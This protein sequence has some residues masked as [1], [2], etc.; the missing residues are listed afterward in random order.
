MNQKIFRLIVADV[1][2]S[3]KPWE[4]LRKWRRALGIRAK[5]VA[6]DIGVSPSVISDYESG[7]RKSP[8]AEMVR[9]IVFS[10]VK[11]S[12]LRDVGEAQI[13]EEH[14]NFEEYARKMNGTIVAHPEVKEAAGIIKV[15]KDNITSLG[16]CRD[17]CVVSDVDGII[18]IL[19]SLGCVPNFFAVKS[20]TDVEKVLAKKF[21]FGIIVF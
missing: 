6:Q 14:I 2:S 20:A 16:D 1:L 7:R 21:G 3:E 11:L 18:L 12:G 8:G 13:E 5:A 17:M 4:E 15:T 10:M 9:K 19:T